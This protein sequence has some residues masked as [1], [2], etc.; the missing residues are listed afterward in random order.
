MAEITNFIGESPAFTQM[1]AKI[2][3]LAPL[4]RPVLILGERGTGKELVAARLNF[5]SQRW[6]RPFLTLNCGAMAE[7]I[8]DSE[9]FG[10]EAGA[11][12]GAV[13][14]R[15]SRFEA[16]D[17]GTLFLDE[18]GNASLAVQEK[19]L[20]VVEYGHFSR[21]GG[22]DEVSVNVRIIAGTNADLRNSARFRADLLDRLSFDVIVIPPLR[23][24]RGDILLL[25]QYFAQKMAAELKWEMFP[26]FSD[27][28]KAQLLGHAWPGNVRELRNVVERSVCHWETPNK[29]LGEVSLDP[30]AGFAAPSME[31]SPAA[32]PE[33]VA[34]PE[35]VAAD[36]F[37]AQVEA[38]ERRLL[39]EA[40]AAQKFN[41]K[42]AAAQLGLS[43]SQF[44]NAAKRLGVA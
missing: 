35:I 24:R 39:Q 43:Y 16:A 7:S 10:H 21:V 15:V 20:R 8:L 13:K 26:G 19:L 22:N 23:E 29:P 3:I 28:A 9:L 44:R 38:L 6:N 34:E 40:L 37:V 14:R 36:G 18:I 11:F 4:E 33:L 27:G 30:F 41:Q 32:V 42:Q 2:S 1:L 17:G 31:S 12:T 25:A 5:L